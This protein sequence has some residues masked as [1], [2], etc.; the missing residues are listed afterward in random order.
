MRYGVIDIGSN[1]IRGVAYNAVGDRIKKIEDKLVMSHILKESPNGILSEYGINRLIAILNKLKYVL[2]D[3][4]CREIFCFATSSLRNIKNIEE[5]HSCI[6]STTG[7]ETDLLSDTD[8]ILYDFIALRTHVPERNAIGL[9]LGGGSCQIIQFEKDNIV[10]SNSY[11]IGSG[12]LKLDYI[13]NKLPDKEDRKKLSFLVKNELS[14][15]TNMF[16]SRYVYA[17]G[18]TAK[19]ALRL[20][21][22]LSNTVQKDNYL[23]LE[24]LEVLSKIADENPDRMYDIITSIVKNRADTII[25]GIV[26]LKTILEVLDVN[27]V[28]IL[29]CS[30][31]EGY[32]LKKIK[33]TLL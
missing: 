1:T 19:H 11:N 17:I 21:N 33:K 14:D 7:I 20:F 30:I 23:N 22:K 10:F 27:G 24:K 28:Y 8:E 18:G 5:V 32:L 26:I 12:R 13:K 4:G 16:G 9:D 31:R 3:C 2:R 25:P 6:L 15:L 29:P